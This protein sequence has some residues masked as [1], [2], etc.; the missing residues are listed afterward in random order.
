MVHAEFL[1]RGG[2]SGAR[3]LRA[4]PLLALWAMVHAGAAVAD[5]DYDSRRAA[6]LR[7]CD[8]P[9]HHGR[10][11]EARTCYRA[12]LRDASTLVRA[13]ATF[14]LGDRKAA[15][16]L[17][18]A[19]IAAE[20]MAVL[21]RLRRGRMYMDAGQN[22]DAAIILREALEIDDKDVG[23][24]LALASL[25]VEQFEGD[26]EEQTTK[27]LQ[28]NANLIEAQLL[29]ASLELEGGRFD[30]A[31]K[32]AQ[33]ALQLTQQQSYPPLEAQALL[34]AIQVIQHRDPG[35]WTRAALAYNPRYGEMFQTLSRFELMRRLYVEADVW[36]QQA[37]KVQPDLWSA[38]RE[39]GL[40][41][42]RLGRVDE[43][44]KHL[45]AAY[46]GGDRGVATVNTLRLLDSLTNF[47]IVKVGSPALNLQLGKKESASLGP[48]VQ[49]IATQAIS[50]FSRRYGYTPT[51]AVTVEIYPNSADFEVRIAGLTGIGLLGVTFG[52][53]LA[54]D[55][56]SGR[57]TGDF[58]WGSVLWHE[59]AH[60]FTLG[61]TKN[62]VP[63]WLSEGLSVYEEWTTG[64]TPGVAVN[65][66]MLDMFKDGK[67]LPVTTLDNGFMRPTYEGQIQIS[68]DQAGF[69]CL[70]AAERFG[71]PKVVEFLRAF[72]DESMTT[73]AAV[74]NVFQVAPEDFDKEFQAFLSKRFAAY[75]ADP[76]RWK[77]L[78]NKAHAM[79]DAHNWSAARE[80]AQ[81]AIEMLP[82]FTQSGSAY[83]VL[84][85]AEEGAGK[86]DAAIA[87][88]LAWRKA[89][90]WDPAAMRKLGAL[91]Q[92]AK[93]NAEATEVLASVNYAD[94]LAVDGHDQL[95]QLLLEQNRGADALREYRVLLALSPL[96][97]A[98]ANYGMA[99][100]FRQTGDNA[101]ARRYLLESLDTAPNYRP[102]QKLLLEMTG[103]RKQ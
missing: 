64:P 30:E 96:D 33:R 17:F 102:A 4:L 18:K 13:E 37:V 45:E 71:F 81:A 36:L 78:M 97:T 77:E 82:E 32:A 40:N 90:G 24:R 58:H 84:A 80:A 8:D 89:G 74:R 44:R 54:M 57:Q 85:A 9:Q 50:T 73:G 20:P 70:F 56:P 6:S 65:P 51:G 99:R 67:L 53:L 16:D 11:E 47:D 25:G 62:R 92:T 95:G 72:N 79:E 101:Q 76:K 35:E 63:R 19:A 98:A 100:S 75:L 48:Y 52:D 49:Q 7:R 43:A 41:L 42:M 28:E 83:E 86:P 26:A 87:A 5:I 60:V 94:P 88:L 21:P 68:Y 23:V 2:R 39:Y 38:Q 46:E 103:D 10:V 22:A 59:M 3:L 34:A 93:R 61:A 69:V 15:D 12:L 29:Q 91:L 1:Y 27:L 14:A 31:T 55:S 66:K